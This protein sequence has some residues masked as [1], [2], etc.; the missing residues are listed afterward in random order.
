VE[1][2]ENALAH[3]DEF[4]ELIPDA[5]IGSR[6]DGTI[7]VANKA[8]FDLLGYRREELIG[9]SVYDLTPT[10]FRSRLKRD[11]E[12]FFDHPHRRT[13]GL[14]QRLFIRRANGEEFPA[15][16]SV[17]IVQSAEGP[18]RIAS[19]RDISERLALESERAD[20]ALR[21]ELDRVRR[22]E[23]I[24]QLAGGI[25]HD[26]NNL[27][28]VIINYA[29]FAAAELDELP[30]VRDDVEQIQ[31]AAH[32]AAALTSQLLIFSR[33][34]GDP[35]RPI[36]LNATIEDLEKLLHRVLGEHVEL[37]TRLE[38][39]LWN[40]VADPSQIEQV[41][42]NLAVNARDAMPEGG[43]LTIRTANVELDEKALAMHPDLEQ[44]GRYVRLTV[45]D[46]GAGM[47]NQT[48]ERVFE[49]FFTTK[50]Q[51]HGTGLG[52]ATAYGS[53]RSHGG[54]IVLHSELGHGT[55][56]EIHLPASNLPT[57][58]EQDRKDSPNRAR[59]NSERVLVVEDEQSVRRMVVRALST[60]G[61]DVVSFARANE[62]LELLGDPDERI[63]LML[64]DVVMPELQG[65]ELADRAIGLK[66]DLPVLFMS[67]YSDLALHRSDGESASTDLIE[68]P[69]TINDLLGAVQR[70]IEQAPR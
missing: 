62:A 22:M 37:R 18:I 28:G 11:R 61:Y 54:D 67:G 39:E 16:I 21:V 14:D 55:T 56:A 49:P 41:V 33:R 51:P 42:I 66:P 50:P 52:L 4:L 46:S 48:L 29:E 23:S 53:I 3:F 13:I 34:E 36:Q 43:A 69:F 12:E 68:K 2:V 19:P 63:D 58:P 65:G 24:G 20:L 8:V 27:L 17:S 10:R 70:A 40:I 47:D 25:A 31:S 35:Q 32:R 6:A 26:F 38:P 5:T 64:T 30:H 45:T 9:M 15:E 44:P 57:I 60:N 1:T 59:G 7:V